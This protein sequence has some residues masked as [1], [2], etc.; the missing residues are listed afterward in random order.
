MMISEKQL[1]ANR[2]NA[3]RSTGPKTD[4]G[5]AASSANALKHGLRS[6][7]VVISGEDARQYEQF[8]QDL[9]E[10]LEPAGVLEGCLVDKIAS[11]LWKLNRTERMEAEIL[12]FLQDKQQKQRAEFA[13]RVLDAEKRLYDTKNFLDDAMA[14]V[15]PKRH[16]SFEQAQEAWLRTDDGIAYQHDNWPKGPDARNPMHVFGA[17]WDQLEEKARAEFDLQAEII[18]AAGS[19]LPA[20]TIEST[21]SEP[22]SIPL[23]PAVVE[24]FEDSNVLLK[25]G[26][27]KTQSE[28]S[29][30]RALNE[31][32]KRQFLRLNG[33][34]QGRCTH[35]TRPVLDESGPKE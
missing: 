28:R 7:Q 14:A 34:L 19:P 5:K 24:D 30:Y 29:F 18:Q 1:Q 17:F 31:L 2:Q 22:E 27:Y 4:E 9:A 15:Q 35:R 8:R 16:V 12:R 20:V 6:Q 23:G 26:R 10:Q 21:Q 11:A 33:G 13:Q 32:Q 3:L 25:F